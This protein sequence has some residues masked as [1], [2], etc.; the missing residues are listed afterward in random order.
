MDFID[1]I[2]S[3]NIER[4]LTE[5][6]K[7]DKS[8]RPINNKTIAHRNLGSNPLFTDNGGHATNDVVSQPSTIDWNGENFGTN[9]NNLVV[10]DNKFTIYKIKT[11]G[12]DKVKSTMDFFKNE[13][14]FR[15]AIDVL[16]GAATRGGKTLYF[17]T[18]TSESFA[19]VS[20]RTQGMSNTFW[21]FSFNNTDWYVMKPN[22]V[23]NLKPST[24]LIKKKEE[25]S[26]N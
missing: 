14:E 12:D 6:S 8:T 7:Y 17:R 4:F 3:E 18:I 15:K 1:R 11:F 23:Q 13:K 19:D 21:E 16:N 20:K 24:L 9:G 22:P 10:S 25:N 26:E 5:A 2:I